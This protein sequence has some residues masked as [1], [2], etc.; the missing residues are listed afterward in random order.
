MSRPAAFT[1]N[2]HSRSFFF[3]I[4]FPISLGYVRVQP[5]PPP[6]S[7]Q[8][9]LPSVLQKE[10]GEGLRESLSS[11]RDQSL[12]ACFFFPSWKKRPIGF[13]NSVLAAS[14]AIMEL[15]VENEPWLLREKRSLGIRVEGGEDND[16]SPPLS[17]PG[18]DCQ[19]AFL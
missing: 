8:S 7:R 18:I 12:W 14:V 3:I 1:R 2:A 15:E 5:P 11:T 13:E 6:F 19:G 10:G 9:L 16:W 17:L 4:I